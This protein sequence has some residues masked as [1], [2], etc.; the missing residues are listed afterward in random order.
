M[1]MLLLSGD[2]LNPD[3]FINVKSVYCATLVSRGGYSVPV[4]AANG[5]IVSGGN[6]LSVPVKAAN[7][8]IVSGGNTL[9][10]PVKAVCGT[11]IDSGADLQKP[12]KAVYG[13][14]LVTEV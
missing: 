8:D 10:I 3:T 12:V 7:G 5:D 9:S 14:L 4:K 2:R 13:Y 11:T 1:F 6:T